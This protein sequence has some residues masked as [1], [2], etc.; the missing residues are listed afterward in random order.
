MT[1]QATIILLIIVV[2]A[3]LK[4]MHTIHQ[5]KI[6]ESGIIIID[7]V[8]V[9]SLERDLDRMQEIRHGLAGAD[10]SLKGRVNALTAAVG[11]LE[12]G[13]DRVVPDST[14][15]ALLKIR[16]SSEKAAIHQLENDSSQ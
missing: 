1:Y 3:A 10:G 4:L 8:E 7:M 15:K 13:Q 16:E 12:T 11:K 5:K 9:H 6:N 14:T 2:S